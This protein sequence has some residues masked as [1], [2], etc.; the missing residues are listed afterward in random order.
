[1]EIH[2]LLSLIR[3]WIGMIILAGLIGGAA[4]LAVSFLQPKVYEADVTLFVNLPNH[5][6]TGSLYGA[7]QAAKAF[8]EFPQSR[9]VLAAALKDVG[10]TSLSLSQLAS[11]VTAVNDVNSQFV[12]V[13]VR[14]TNPTRAA[15][16]AN[17]I[18]KQSVIQFE[19]SANDASSAKEF[20]REELANLQTEIKN[21]ENQLASLQGQ[22]T[23]SA[24]SSPS[25]TQTAKVQE[26]NTRLSELR[27]LYNQ[28]VNSYNNLEGIQITVLQ[29]AAIPQVPVSPKPLFAVLIGMLVGLVAIVS[30]IFF[31]EQYDDILRTSA[32][33][34]QKT[35]LSTFI[36]VKHLPA[37]K[38]QVPWL[39]GHYKVTEDAAR[40]LAAVAKEATPLP[41][42][43][44]E[45]GEDTSLEDTAKLPV[46]TKQAPASLGGPK[47]EKKVSSRFQLPEAFL[48][49]GVLLYNQHGQ[50]AS[51]GSNTGS[52]LI[53]SPEN[54][55]GKTIIASLIAL[56]L[57]RIGVEV[58]LVDANIRKPK[59]HSIFGL[60][61][62]IGL[63]SILTASPLDDLTTPLV[64]PIHSV[65][66]SQLVDYTFAA[67]EETQEPNLTI[68][69]A[70]PVLNSPPEIL[71]SPSLTA[72]LR[73]LS[74]KAFVVI[75]SPAVLTSSEPV[76]LANKS[77]GILMVVDARN[78]TASKLNQSLE[79]LKRVNENILGVVLNNVG[80]Q[81]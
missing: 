6:D 1:M 81:I 24:S 66:S 15:R 21:Q 42:P 76:L 34:S 40:S 39:N 78:T 5:G 68:L 70:G 74:E 50:L 14:D 75:D 12:V 28:L 35:G 67:L 26:L 18:A 9:P 73:K 56:G 60:S 52:L 63:S 53:T 64:D 46:L 17:E 55:D 23:P 16:L 3:K 27:T 41:T 79:I 2:D 43:W 7:Q 13:M 30:V 33:V 65:P 25:P 71:S 48:T 38:K 58:I 69:S 47:V 51:N 80:K 77:D 57:A 32:K 20:V 10:D 37:I 31:I 11:M 61:N 59:I 54:G 22:A 49:L 29:E 36:T 19:I 44:P 62:K 72:I 45:E 8:A 4:G